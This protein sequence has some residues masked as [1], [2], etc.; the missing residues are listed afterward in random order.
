MFLGF[1]KL[2]KVL[3]RFYVLK[4]YFCESSQVSLL[5]FCIGNDDTAC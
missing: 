3:I 1:K 2:R 5:E 4:A